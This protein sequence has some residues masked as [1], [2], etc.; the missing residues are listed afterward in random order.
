MIFR[1]AG[2]GQKYNSY[3]SDFDD[4]KCGLLPSP[5]FNR[6]ILVPKVSS[7]ERLKNNLIV[8]LGIQETERKAIVEEIT[9]AGACSLDILLNSF[10]D[11]DD[12]P[13]K[14]P[15]T[16]NPDETVIAKTKLN[17]ASLF[18]INNGNLCLEARSRF[19]RKGWTPLG[20]KVGKNNRIFVQYAE[21]LSFIFQNNMPFPVT[22]TEPFSPV[23]ISEAKQVE[24]CY[25]GLRQEDSIK[26]FKN[27]QDVTEQ[28]KFPFDYFDAFIVHCD[29]QAVY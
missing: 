25:F 17:Y 26:L 3:E 28:N 1:S 11:S 29:S 21:K 15:F 7:G 22:V 9:T 10:F 23:Q 18:G 4:N 16:V 20:F 13:L 2:A 5:S 19:A 12:R 27:S 24:Q 8:N 14:F 6:R